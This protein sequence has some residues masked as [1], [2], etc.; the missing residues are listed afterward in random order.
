MSKNREKKGWKTKET[1]QHYSNVVEVV[2][3][4]RREIL[5]MIA[6]LSTEFIS[7]N[8]KIL[9]LGCGFGDVTAEILKLNA[10][11]EVVMMDF[12]DEM[13][14]LSIER[15][16]ENKKIKIIKRDLNY[17]LPDELINGE[18]DAVVSC[19][20][21]HHIDFENRVKLYSDINNSL[22]KEG[23]FVNGDLFKGD[24]PI[25]NQWEFDNWIKWMVKQI[26][27]KFNKEK[28]FEEVKQKQLKEFEEK[29]DKPGTV[30]D[31]YNDLKEAEF[32]HV[33]CLLKDHNLAV[34]SATN[35]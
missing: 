6:R 25:I 17:G 21:L 10:N 34:L 30:W 20:A 22:K 12:S 23:I 3:P 18:F 29:E 13:I 32:K 9:D 4:S 27:D 28:T 1:I 31:M 2:V 24:S 14:K 16:K 26:K 7:G 19:F 8:P 11:A 33:D 35:K 15:F 5:K